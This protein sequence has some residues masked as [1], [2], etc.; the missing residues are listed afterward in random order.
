MSGSRLGVVGQRVLHR[1]RAM[2]DGVLGLVPAW[3]GRV[4]GRKDRGDTAMFLRTGVTLL[5]IPWLADWIDVVRMLLVCLVVD[6]FFPPIALGRVPI[7]LLCLW[8]HHY[9]S[10]ILA[11]LCVL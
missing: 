9:E 5:L 4:R 8:D 7:D 10:L 11:G 1:Q 2:R 6:F 3:I